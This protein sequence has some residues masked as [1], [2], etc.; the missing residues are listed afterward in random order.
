MTIAR[1]MLGRTGF[2]ASQIGAGDLADRSLTLEE[3]VVTLTRA[4]DAGVNVVDTAPGYESGFS[5]QIVRYG[6]TTPAC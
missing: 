6:R 2:N 3:C 1:R 5:E 4:L